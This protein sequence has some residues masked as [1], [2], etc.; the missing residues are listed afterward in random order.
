MKIQV[1]VLGLEYISNNII[2]IHGFKLEYEYLDR[3]HHF[4]IK[5]N[6]LNFSN[7]S[8]TLNDCTH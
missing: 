6:C 2:K 5:I 4:V 1:V 3:Y 7:D 8:L